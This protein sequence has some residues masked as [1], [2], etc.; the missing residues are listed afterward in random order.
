MSN[1]NDP[2]W[3]YGI[4]VV[5]EEQKGY[6]YIQC[7]FCDRVL[8]GGVFRMKEHLVGVQGSVTERGI[9]GPMDR[10]VVN[11]EN[12]VVEDL[13]GSDKGMKGLEKEAHENTCLD[14]ADFFYENGLAFNVAKG[15]TQE[16]VK[17]VKQTWNFLVNN[18]KG[19]MFLKSIDASDAIKDATL[20]FNLLDSVV[21]E[22]GEDLVV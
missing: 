6:K 13:G 10:F 16:V 20:L 1:R 3:K 15:K 17:E 7:K 19:T 11:V 8:K 5:M 22:V 21:E 2:A 14:I 12:D 18:L 4:E 9:K